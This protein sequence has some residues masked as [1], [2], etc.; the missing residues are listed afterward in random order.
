MRVLYITHDGLTDN[1]GQSQVLPYLLGLAREGFAITV[2]SAE[3]ATK[4]RFRKETA[5]RLVSA[6]IDW[7]FI[8]YHNKPPLISTVFD[9]F[10]IYRIATKIIRN[11]DIR[12]IHCRSFLPMSIGLLIKRHVN[13]PIIFD[14]R[15]FWAD[16]RMYSN[17]YK[18]VYRFFKRREG[19]MIRNSNHIVT[20]TDKAKSILQQAYM[21]DHRKSLT[22]RFTVIPTCAD[23]DLFDTRGISDADRRAIREGLGIGVSD[24]VFGYLGTFHAD[25]IPAE[26]FRAFRML[27][28]IEPDTKFLFVSPTDRAEIIY[29][30]QAYGV[31]ETDIR[32]VSATRLEVPHY[33]S[34]FDL[35]IV[36]IRA[37]PSTAGVSPTKLAELFAC[38]IPV[39]ANAGVGDLDDIVKPEVNDS[40][41]VHDFSDE[42]LKTAI[43]QLMGIVRSPVRRGRSASMQFSLTEGIRR[44]STVYSRFI[45]PVRS[46]CSTS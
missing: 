41:L 17:P 4:S 44:Y 28:S 16:R 33:L 11:S 35:S 1:I 46:S 39:L 6:G 31:N 18:F 40:V 36:F 34:V 12:L 27:R 42:S 14:F 3:K 22:E 13:I 2:V 30:A 20:L 45:Q 21:Q 24:L 32:V 43:T 19:W 7:R 9:L 8:T 29:H 25:Y 23:V 10:C 38:N 26:M 5:E 15:D 37:D